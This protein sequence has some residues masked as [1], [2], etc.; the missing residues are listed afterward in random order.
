[1]SHEGSVVQFPRS[2]RL[3][4][5][6]QMVCATALGIC[7]HFFPYSPRRLALV[8]RSEELNPRMGVF[9]HK[10]LKDDL[11]EDATVFGLHALICSR[12]V[13]EVACTRGP[14]RRMSG[15]LGQAPK[16]PG[17]R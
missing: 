3:P 4:L 6:L 14:F 1:M 5:G 11:R 8:G 12:E 16:P 13:S 10:A 15:Q 9:F 7:I 17:Y 2:F